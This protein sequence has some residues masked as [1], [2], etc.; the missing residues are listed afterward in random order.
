MP[1]IEVL[2]AMSAAARLLNSLAEAAVTLNNGEPLTPEQIDRI[3]GDKVASESE[4]AAA[5]ARLRGGT[6]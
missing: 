3:Q 2:A 6:Q 1:L 5:L 4:W